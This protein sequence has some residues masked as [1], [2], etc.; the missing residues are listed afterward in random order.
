MSF[1][2][3]LWGTNHA[4]GLGL[5]VLLAV[6]GDGQAGAQV[7]EPNGLMVPQ[8]VQT[9]E[10]SIAT[11]RGF[12]AEALTLQGL[13]GPT[14]FNDM[15][16]PVADADTQPA[17]FSPLCG[18]TGTL[19]MRG[20]GCRLDFGWYNA[21]QSGQTPTDAEIFTLVPANPTSMDF[22]PL[23]GVSTQMQIGNMCTSCPANRGAAAMTF[24]AQA[25]RDDM[26]YLSPD[27]GG[28][29]LI[30]FALRGAAGT[31]CTQTHFS[32]N[33]LNP[34]CT[35]GCTTPG[36]WVMTLVYTSRTMADSFFLAFEDLP[37]TNFGPNDGQ[38]DGD[39]NDFVYLITGLTCEGGGQPCTRPDRMG[40]CASGVT[41]CG[42]GGVI[43][44]SG[45]LEP[46]AEQCD[47]IDNDCNGMVDDDPTLCTADN[48]V[49]YQ[50]KC[51]PKCGTGE[52]SCGVGETCVEGICLDLPC[53]GVTC[54]AEQVC[55]G[56]NCVGACTDVVCPLT[57]NG[58]PEC[59]L[60][61]CADPCVSAACDTLGL[62]CEKGSCV[63]ACD[64]RQCPDG[65]ACSPS[66]VCVD[67]ACAT[68]QCPA[69]QICFEGACQDPCTGAVCPG[70]ALCEGGVCGPPGT[71]GTGGNAGTSGN[72]GTAGVI[73]G[74]SSGA[75][76]GGGASSGASGGADGD[77]DELGT[78][79]GNPGC[80]CRVE[81]S[82]DA[83]GFM[84][85]VAGALVG[86][87]RARRRQRS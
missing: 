17:I 3:F 55:R 60:G 33:D 64:C 35:T 1:S 4:R 85:L 75:R 26:R 41:S 63:R 19:V 58:R 10:T 48:K 57:V 21:T 62:V 59:R 16:D 6:L 5:G 40:A 2:G 51:V 69:G 53:M 27:R 14:C 32:E 72:T 70:G 56:G 23:A 74:N 45:G 15:I 30:G 87:L 83:S 38:N 36:P 39:F 9:R 8:P 52:F 78:P 20:G 50:G 25:I 43:T 24:E 66:G 65:T 86:A 71:S 81:G 80:A 61:R 22:C 47:N 77:D 82:R 28:T 49:C 31:Q 11:A 7:I 44:C 37:A 68:M 84:L 13:F 73:A 29:G 46:T 79:K 76:S 54:P 12:P 67:T 42:P 18:F 34:D